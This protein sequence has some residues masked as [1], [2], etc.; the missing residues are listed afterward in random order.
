MNPDELQR[1]TS[2]LQDK[3]SSIFYG[4]KHTFDLPRWKRNAHDK[5]SGSKHGR[6]YTK[7][8]LRTKS[9]K[10]KAKTRRKMAK[11]SRKINWGK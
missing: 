8:P 1:I 5:T 4:P 2:F 11:M 6:P 9:V 7:A 10:A 3:F